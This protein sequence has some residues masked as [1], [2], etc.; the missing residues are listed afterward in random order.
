MVFIFSGIY[1]RHKNLFGTNEKTVKEQSRQTRAFAFAY[2]MMRM[3]VYE[4]S[5]FLSIVID[6]AAQYTHVP[7]QDITD[8]FEA[9]DSTI[10]FRIID[11]LINSTNASHVNVI[12]ILE[13]EDETIHF[14]CFRLCFGWSH[15]Q[16]KTFSSSL[17]KF[18]I[19]SWREI[20][21]SIWGRWSVTVGKRKPM[22]VD[23]EWH[24]IF[25]V[26]LGSKT[27]KFYSSDI[28]DTQNLC[29]MIENARKVF[30]SLSQFPS[31][32]LNG[33]FNFRSVMLRE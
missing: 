15:K 7:E 3:T 19:N 29:R 33:I 21:K 32:F 14:C 2:S 5:C 6:I 28:L 26:S 17:R 25:K 1:K 24:K 8:W 11:C 12:Y 27:I 18:H 9:T 30:S 31:T 10:A 20:K 23:W 22:E 13:G 16:R 4:G